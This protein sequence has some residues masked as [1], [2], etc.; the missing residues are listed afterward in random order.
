METLPNIGKLG[1]R[2]HENVN[3]PTSEMP[4]LALWLHCLSGRQAD[5]APMSADVSLWAQWDL[6]ER[7]EEGK[8]HAGNSVFYRKPGCGVGRG[9]GAFQGPAELFGKTFIW[10]H[11]PKEILN[12]GD[13]HTLIDM[14]SLAGGWGDLQSV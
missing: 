11:H 9:G 14:E 10:F 8:T 6:T 7:L 13:S 12:H 5:L 2:P 3:P 1:P 4:I